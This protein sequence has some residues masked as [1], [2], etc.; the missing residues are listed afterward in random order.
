MFYNKYKNVNLSC[1]TKICSKTNAL[2]IRFY[3]PFYSVPFFYTMNFDNKA[4]MKLI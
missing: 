3:S 4:N 1:T 2:K